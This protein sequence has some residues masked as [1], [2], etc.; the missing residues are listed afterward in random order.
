ME[1]AKLWWEAKMAQEQ[2]AEAQHTDVDWKKLNFPPGAGLVHIDSNDLKNPEQKHFLYMNYLSFFFAIV[3]YGT[4]SSIHIIQFSRGRATIVDLCVAMLHGIGGIALA[5]IILYRAFKG[6]LLGGGVWLF[7]KVLEGLF[8][9]VNFYFM[10]GS[11]VKMHGISSLFEEAK[12]PDADMAF[13][14]LASIEICMVLAGCTLR[15]INLLECM[16]SLDK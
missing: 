13:I 10:L 6:V 14:W 12:K 8:I 9:F 5:F 3:M 7:Y 11:R 4:M 2:A 15:T 1:I 16:Y